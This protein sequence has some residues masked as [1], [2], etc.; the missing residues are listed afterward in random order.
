MLMMKRPSSPATPVRV[1]SLHSITITAS[2]SASTVA[3]DLDPVHAGE[4]QVVLGRGV[5]VDEPHLL[6]ER[7]ERVGHRQLRPDRVAVGPRV[8]GQQETLPL[9]DFVADLP[10]TAGGRPHR[11]GASLGLLGHHG[12]ARAGASRAAGHGPRRRVRAERSRLVRSTPRV[13]CEDPLDA[14]VPLDA[15][16]VEELELRCPAQPQ[17]P[18]DLTAQERRRAL[19]RPRRLAPRLLVA[20]RR[21]VDARVLQVG[22][23][24]DAG[25]GEEADARVVHLRAQQ[26]RRAP[27]GSGRRRAPD[28]R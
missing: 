8:R 4:L 14:V 10:T 23:H 20:E 11:A 18:A 27:R 5:G 1:R 2:A 25:D 19:E 26:F 9:Q 16:V 17:P 3:R 12:G 28:V 6:A 7:L 24:L 21:V 13:S 22:R 15:L